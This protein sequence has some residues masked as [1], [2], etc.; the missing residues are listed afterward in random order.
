MKKVKR[1]FICAL[2]FATLSLGCFNAYATSAI[3]AV[4]ENKIYTEKK[5]HINPKYQFD[6]LEFYNSSVLNVV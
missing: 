5:T 4:L 3:K 2:S 6:T 1:S